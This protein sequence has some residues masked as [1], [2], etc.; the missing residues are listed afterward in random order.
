M[1]KTI[2]AGFSAAFIAAACA[3]GSQAAATSCAD[4]GACAPKKTLTKKTWVKK[5]SVSAKTIK[6]KRIT[7]ER[8]A[9]ARKLKTRRV[10]SERVASARR[11]SGKRVRSTSALAV[12]APRGRGHV[13]AM[14]KAQA[15]RY[16]VPTWFALRIAHVE[17]G[18]NPNARG[19]AGELGVFQMKCQ[20][21]RGLGFRGSCS[22]LLN[23]STGVQW[24][25]RHLQAAVRS[26]RGNL[27]LAAS[28]HNGG[29]GRKSLVS[30]YV[31]R[32]F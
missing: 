4:Y 16:G 19:A 1:K 25:L 26:S 2:L 20:T 14:I 32:V 24:G 7:S 13:V 3:S 31:S 17:S 22:Q 10:K 8:V 29:L 6:K 27:R 28:K 5:K 18:Y 30:K 9:T 15:P 12:A 21:A 11:L 23:P